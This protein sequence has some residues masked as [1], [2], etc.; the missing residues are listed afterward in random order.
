MKA[1]SLVWAGE[2]QGATRVDDWPN[3]ARALKT[4][5]IHTDDFVGTIAFQASLHGD[6]DD[7]DWFDFQVEEFGPTLAHEDK[8]R[9]RIINSRDRFIWMRVVIQTTRG[10][11]DRILVI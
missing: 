2:A 10:R 9:N 4:I 6:P 8:K 11:V 7:G 3:P 5:M 1:Q